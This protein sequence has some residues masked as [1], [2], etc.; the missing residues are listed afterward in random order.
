M[1]WKRHKRRNKE[2][3]PGFHTCDLIAEW[4]SQRMLEL[5]VTLTTS[6]STASFSN[7][8]T[9]PQK[10]AVEAEMGRCY[11]HESHFPCHQAQTTS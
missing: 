6:A 4:S 10:E 2:G 5:E 3:K 9:E 11:S 7:N 8:K 1:K